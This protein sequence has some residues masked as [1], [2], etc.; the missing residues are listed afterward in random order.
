MNL[1]STLRRPFRFGQ[2]VFAAIAAAVDALRGAKALVLVEDPTQETATPEIQR[3]LAYFCPTVPWAA[4]DKRRSLSLLDFFSTTPILLAGPTAWPKLLLKLRQRVFNVDYARH[5]EDAWEWCRFSQ[6]HDQGGFDRHRRDE[7]HLIFQK[8]IQNARATQLHRTYLFG[9]GKSLARALHEDFSD[10]YRVVCNTIVRDA[11]LWNHL[12]PHYV[13]AGDAV[14]HFG[15]TEHAAA[16]RQDL[17]ARL[18]APGC[19]TIFAYPALF[20]SVV[21]R[22]FGH[23][24]ERLAP[25]PFGHHQDI[26]VDLYGNFELPALGNVLNNLLLPLGCTLTKEVYLWGFDGRAP[27]DKNFW[28][29]SGKHSYAEYMDA[30]SSEHPAF[31]AKHVPKSRPEEYVQKV[32]GDELDQNLRRAESAGWRFTMLHD[33]W[34]A[35]LKKRIGTRKNESLTQKA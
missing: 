23:I 3:R 1:K 13:V 32:H 30:L 19:Q 31:F 4:V 10:G 8:S 35:T 28:S 21:L 22:Q 6:E 29:N 24:R 9:T 34:T 5:F 17:L 2:V 18:S 33:T 7:A 27:D 25:I 14:Y 26:A 11:E 12:K 20:D 15:Q 16:F